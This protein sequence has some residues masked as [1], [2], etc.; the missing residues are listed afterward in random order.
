M[1]VGGLEEFKRIVQGATAC[2]GAPAN[3]TPAQI[4]ETADRL[5]HPED[6]YRQHERDAAEMR[7]RIEQLKRERPELTAPPKVQLPDFL[8]EAFGEK[9]SVASFEETIELTPPSSEPRIGEWPTEPMGA[10]E[11]SVAT[12]T[13]TG[14]PLEKVQI[15]LLPTNDSSTIPAYALGPLERVPRARISHRCSSLVARAIRSRDRRLKSRRHEHPGPEQAA[16]PRGGAR[17]RSRTVRL[18]Q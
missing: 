5:H 9:F 15:V 4:I 16:K 11:L 6:I 8:K 10:P 2:P 18:L 3:R 17:A 12:E 7:E 1:V 13:L 14:A